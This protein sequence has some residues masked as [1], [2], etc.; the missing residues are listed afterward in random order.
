MLVLHAS[1]PFRYALTS[2]NTVTQELARRPGR[3]G[4]GFTP[5]P[6]GI[7]QKRPSGSKAR[8]GIARVARV[9][10]RAAIRIEDGADLCPEEE[11][12][13]EELRESKHSDLLRAAR[14]RPPRPER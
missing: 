14:L 9:G 13:I 12:E 3:S 5:G 11:Q 7:T 4:P 2:S 8:A 10:L 6:Q 1:L